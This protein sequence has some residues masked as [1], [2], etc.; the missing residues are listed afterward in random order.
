ML[1]VE[2]RQQNNS[3]QSRMEKVNEGE[4]RGGPGGYRKMNTLVPVARLL[5]ITCQESA[6]LQMCHMYTVQIPQRDLHLPAL[7]SGEQLAERESG[8][9][10]GKRECGR[11]RESERAREK[12][13]ERDRE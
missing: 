5:L 12:E 7:L 6:V 9:G 1:P 8:N 3:K 4:E 10:R 11:K 13:G 2:N